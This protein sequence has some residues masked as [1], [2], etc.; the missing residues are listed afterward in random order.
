MGRLQ[1][2]G[3]GWGKVLGGTQEVIDMARE[4]VVGH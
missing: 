4:I 1:V 3:E 2:D